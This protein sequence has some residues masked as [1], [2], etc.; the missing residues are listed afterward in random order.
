[1]TKEEQ[2]Q[3]EVV[4]KVEKV[5]GYGL[6]GRSFDCGSQVREPPLRMTNS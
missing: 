5:C 3:A 2:A 4:E 1:M 6:G